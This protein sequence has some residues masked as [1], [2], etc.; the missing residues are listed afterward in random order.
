MVNAI[1]EKFFEIAKKNA[2]KTAL[3]YKKEGVYFPVSYKELSEKVINLAAAFKKINI[4]KGD[5]VAILSENRPEWLISDLAIMALGAITAPLHTT[6]SSKALC[7]ILNHAEAKTL[8]VSNMELLNKVLLMQNQL[9][10][11]ER[12]IF[13]EKISESQKE[14]I[15]MDV[16][17]WDK[18]L[19]HSKDNIEI[20]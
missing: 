8:I 13:M 1:P 16:F 7:N 2:K 6:L 17:T 14:T 3:L 20:F 19:N 18:F 4:E 15:D 12:I 11:L 5:R 9:N 10:S